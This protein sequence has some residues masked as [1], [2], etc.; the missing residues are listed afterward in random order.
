MV[1]EATITVIATGLESADAPAQ[2]QPAAGNLLGNMKYPAGTGTGAVNRPGT[3]N[4][5]GGLHTSTQAKP[6]SGMSSTGSMPS[7]T[8]GLT[9]PQAPTSNIKEQDIKIPDFLKNTRK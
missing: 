8:Q 4:I 9:K 6:A 5:G 2:A 1:D 7:F 3:Q